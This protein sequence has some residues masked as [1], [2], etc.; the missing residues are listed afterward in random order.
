[1]ELVSQTGETNTNVF[2]HEMGHCFF[3]D[4]LYDRGKYPDAEGLPS[5]MNTSGEISNFDIM[6]LRM[7]WKHQ[8]NY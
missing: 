6:T 5:I 7:V 3:L 8:K 2:L 1:M 4:D